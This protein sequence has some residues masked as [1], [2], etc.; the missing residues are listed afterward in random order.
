[1]LFFIEDGEQVRAPR[2]EKATPE[3]IARK[4][5]PRPFR[6]CLAAVMAAEVDAQRPPRLRPVKKDS[7]T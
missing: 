7:D 1:M 2:P 6:V 4:V 5:G 3:F